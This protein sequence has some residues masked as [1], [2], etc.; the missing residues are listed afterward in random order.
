MRGINFGDGEGA[1]EPSVR[2]GNML[3]SLSPELLFRAIESDILDPA[4][5][6]ISVEPSER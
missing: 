4:L 1:T 6:Q 2:K 3:R 5:N